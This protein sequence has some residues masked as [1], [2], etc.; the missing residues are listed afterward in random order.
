MVLQDKNSVTILLNHGQD[1]GKIENSSFNNVDLSNCQQQQL[2]LE[3]ESS[4]V[5]LLNLS[6]T[7]NG[8]AN[9]RFSIQS[10]NSNSSFVTDCSTTM[11]DPGEAVSLAVGQELEE[12][13]GQRDGYLEPFLHQVGGHGS[14]LRWDRRTVCKP[15]SPKE[16]QFY[17]ELH[18]QLREFVP[19]YGGPFS[20]ALDTG[21]ESSTPNTSFYAQN[22]WAME[23]QARQLYK[24][25]KK[26][27]EKQKFILLENLACDFHL[28][29]VLDLKMGFRQHG[30]DAPLAKRNSQMMKCK[31]STSSVLGVRMCGMQVYHADSG[32]FKCYNKY[33]G[34]ALSVDGFKREISK[35]WHNGRIFRS[36]LL[37]KCVEKLK[38]LKEA[39]IKCKGYGF[40][41]S[42]LLIIYDGEFSNADDTSCSDAKNDPF[43]HHSHTDIDDI[44]RKSSPNRAVAN[45]SAA[46]KVIVKMIDFEHATIPSGRNPNL[47]SLGANLDDQCDKGYVEGITNLINILSNLCSSTPIST[48]YH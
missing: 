12:C 9:N 39:V 41:S 40:Y 25:Q 20:D 30:D 27:G 35:F 42:S 45:H 19:E 33:Y 4:S 37:P 38:A 21:D 47:S 36:D 14:V 6:T 44:Q 5:V 16:Q 1:D 31:N 32:I 2:Q 23:C 43:R 24:M 26:L 22:P 34:R 8:D 7:N 15:F 10:D 3:Q 11:S 13:S 18:P 46:D 48:S 17:E 29:C 28:P